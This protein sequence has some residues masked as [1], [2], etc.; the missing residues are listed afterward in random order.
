M[1]S[2]AAPI[3]EAWIERETLRTRL[4]RGLAAA[5]GLALL[6][7]AGV[8]LFARSVR[9]NVPGAETSGGDWLANHRAETRSAP[10]ARWD[11]LWYASIAAEG[12]EGKDDGKMHNVAFFPLYPAAVLALSKLTGLRPFPAGAAV[13]LASFL[14]AIA[15]LC[16]LARE[17]GF[18]EGVTS[19]AILWFPTSFFFLAVYSESL[20]LFVS[21]GCF[22]ALRRR[23]F[24]EGALWGFFCG[25]CRPNGFL[26][27][28]PIAWALFEER[29]FRPDR[30]RLGILLA[31][32]GPWLGLASFL[33]YIGIRLGDPFLPLKVQKSGWHHRLTWPWRPLIEG[34]FW[35]PYHR[36]EVGVA[37]LFGLI[38]LI[39]WRTRK[40]YALYVW[41]S[42]LM[43]CISGTIMSLSRFVLVLVPAFLVIGEGLRKFRWL[44]AVYATLGLLA[45]A[46]FTMRF[47]LGFWVA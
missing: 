45:L 22:L 14:G 4:P 10:L 30:R 9:R 27:S 7:S 28:I 42:L 6:W 43:V 44:E 25:L 12:Y 18:D 2:D 32:S 38:G 46:L 24:V 19:R 29:P 39:L 37:T 8:W 35:R 21:V 11:S 5:L 31:A 16:L 34:W 36:F 15:L 17:E 47:A 20:F 40:G 33:A 3:R 23:R 41:A 13:S 26:V 1:E